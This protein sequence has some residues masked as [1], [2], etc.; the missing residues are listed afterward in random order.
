MFFYCNE[1]KLKISIKI[2]FRILT[3]MR[4]LNNTLINNPWVKEEVTRSWEIL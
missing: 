4:E 2:K 1:M 3:N